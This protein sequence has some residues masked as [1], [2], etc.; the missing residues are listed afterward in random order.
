M[1]KDSISFRLERSA[2]PVLTRAAKAAGMKV[3]NYVEAAVLEK[4]G[5]IEDRRTSQELEDLRG[6]I[7]ILREEL[8]IATEA[9]LVIVGSQKPYSAEAAKSWVSS[10]LKRREAR[11]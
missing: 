7:R 9:T 6:E 11:K 2:R 3:S 1:P 8:A 5:E 10:N 4:L